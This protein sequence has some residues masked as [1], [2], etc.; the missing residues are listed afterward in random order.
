MPPRRTSAPSSSTSARCVYT[1]IYEPTHPPRDQD[2][3]RQGRARHWTRQLGATSVRLPPGQL[4]LRLPVGGRQG[5][6]EQ[7]PTRLDLAC[8][9]TETQRVRP[10]EFMTWCRKARA[11]SSM[12]AVNLGTRGIDVRPRHCWSTA[13]STAGTHLSDLRVANGAKEP[14]AVRM[15]CLGNE[16]DG[17]WQIGHKSAREY[18][19]LA[20]ETRQGDAHLLDPW[21]R[22][23]A[24]RQLGLQHAD[25]RRVGG[26]RC[27]RRPTTSSTSSPVTPY[28]EEHDGD[29]ASFLARPWTWTTSSTP[30]WPPPTASA[31]AQ[32]Q[33]ED[34]HLLRRVERLVLV[35]LP[36]R[37]AP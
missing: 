35:A 10:D 7:R 9:S 20:A 4:R 27:W 17:P 19:R 11:S 2:G 12:M 18:G 29:L 14:H 37:R 8:H 6:R 25:L 13:T 30:W 31:P 28:Y 22:L 15:W 5:P 26:H 16:M 32:E 34:Q 36:E 21:P 24:C 23:V 1:G 33:E 3:F